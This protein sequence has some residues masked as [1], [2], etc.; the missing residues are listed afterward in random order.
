[1]KRTRRLISW[2]F[3]VA[4]LAGAVEPAR[5]EFIQSFMAMVGPDPVNFVKPQLV[6]VPQF[7]PDKG[8]LQFVVV[9]ITAKFDAFLQVENMSETPANV[10]VMA[11]ET[12]HVTPPA[13]V[14]PVTLTESEILPAT[15][16]PVGPADA[17]GPF[18]GN[19]TATFTFEPVNPREVLLANVTLNPLDPDFGMFIGEGNLPDFSVD[20]T[21]SFFASS[22][23]GN[24]T[25]QAVLKAG[26][27]IEVDYHFIPEPST[28]TLL[29]LGL[30]LVLRRRRR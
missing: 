27:K 15:T 4:A 12:V 11:T 19:D 14:F 3:V 20:A 6:T 1:M 29:V 26:A 18:L 22:N 9:R 7:D 10:T 8:I 16:K 23:T 2:T 5:A 13:F 24:V 21:G 25:S 28:L 30:P 17:M